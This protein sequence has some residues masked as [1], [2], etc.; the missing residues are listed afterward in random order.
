M[1]TTFDIEFELTDLDDEG[2]DVDGEPARVDSGC[3]I[4][5]LSGATRGIR[6]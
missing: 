2:I 4:E 1:S 5:A 6:R 3:T